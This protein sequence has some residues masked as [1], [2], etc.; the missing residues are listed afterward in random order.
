MPFDFVANEKKWQAEWENAKIFEANPDPK[1]KKFLITFPYPY[2]NGAMHVGHSYSFFRTDVYARFKRMQ[3]Y[4]TLFP[5]GFHATGEPIMGTV[6]RLRKGDLAQVENFKKAGATNSEIEGFKKGP[7]HVAK[8]WMQKWISDLKSAGASIDWR[9]KFITTDLTPQ[10]SRFIE[11]QYNTLRKKGYVVQG[12]HPVIWCPHDKSPTGDHDRYTGEGESPIEYTIIKFEAEINGEKIILPCATLR[13]ETTYG[14]TNIWLNPD[15]KYVKVKVD[16]QMWVVS[17]YAALKLSDQQHILE[18]AI[19]IGPRSLIGKKCKISLLNS[20]IPILPASFVSPNTGTGVVMGVPAHA[21]Y[22]YIALED[23][24]KKNEG[25]LASLG[26]SK[27]LLASITP[28]SLIS[29]EGHGNYPAIEECKKLGITSQKDA[30]KL[31]EATSQIYKLEFHK[32]IL[33]GMFGEFA[34]KSISESK[35]PIIAKFKSLK[36]ASSMWESTGDVVCRCMAKCH[37]KILE[38]QWFLK[39]SDPKWK[40]AVK[41]HLKTMPIFP[42]DARLQMENTIDWLQNKACARKGGLGTRLP[43]DKEWKVETL[44]DSTIYM[45]YYTIARAINEWGILAEKLTDEVFDYIFLGIGDLDGISKRSG[46][47]ASIISE[48]KAE[49]AYFYPVDLRNSG[50]DLLQNHLLFLLFHHVAIFGPQLSPRAISVNGY[51]TVE[52]EKMSKSK[53]NFL[54]I[55]KMLTEYGADLVRINITAAGEGLDDAN[56]REEGIKTYNRSLE[57]ILG[58]V[59]KIK[60]M[61]GLGG[62]KPNAHLDSISNGNPLPTNQPAFGREEKLLQSRIE[63]SLLS[64]SAAMEKMEFRTAIQAIVFKGVEALRQYANSKGEDADVLLVRGCL[65]RIIPMLCPFTPHF[66]EEAWKIMGK[67]GYCSD[68]AYPIPDPSKINASLE[69]GEKYLENVASDVARIIQITSSSPKLIRLY[70]CEGW[71]TGLFK[72]ALNKAQADGKFDVPSLIKLAMADGKFKPHAKLVPQF[73]L[74]ISKSVNYYKTVAIPEFDEFSLLS[75]SLPL[76][77]NRFGCKVEAYLAG[78][79]PIDADPQGKAQRSL[80]LKPAIFLSP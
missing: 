2:L 28:I 63:S 44:S 50:K 25:E 75:Q 67:T 62:K 55:F 8:F 11:W 73:L 24:K 7:E 31:V 59:E 1:R 35:D 16:G 14:A 38:N 76:F 27:S 79:L 49:F 3:G 22:D 18:G 13:P 53:G 64:A 30:V 65:E 26:I 74:Q 9:R 78:N 47:P 72:L 42:N 12:T 34:G 45:A 15:E 71:K 66:S 57:F 52:G 51:V 48:M 10:Y 36:I 40:E 33:K 23:L 69:E 54:P 37:V 4:N 41:S 61:E 77:E 46:L 20:P 17:E 21:P 32:G 58:Q 70:A 39:F 43:W 56:W 6:E 19:P 68:A 5:Q 29:I 80:P 60:N